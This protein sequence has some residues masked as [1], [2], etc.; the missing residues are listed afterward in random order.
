M[1]STEIQ[2]YPELL[3]WQQLEPFSCQHVIVLVTDA[4]ALGSEVSE[5]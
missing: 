5:Q 1:K 4:K 2:R 3:S